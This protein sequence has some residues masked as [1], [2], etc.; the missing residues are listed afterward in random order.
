MIDMKDCLDD[1][2]V[3]YKCDRCAFS[4][5]GFEAC[6]NPNIWLDEPRNSYFKARDEDLTMEEK[7]SIYLTFDS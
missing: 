1:D 4:K 7:E 5:D 2:G 6:A 3:S